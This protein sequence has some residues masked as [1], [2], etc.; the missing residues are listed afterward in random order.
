MNNPRILFFVPGTAV[1]AVCALARPASA[2]VDY[3]AERRER[4]LPVARAAAP[5]TLD[6]ALDEAAW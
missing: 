6:G 2:Q 4:H 3:E 5:I 1:L